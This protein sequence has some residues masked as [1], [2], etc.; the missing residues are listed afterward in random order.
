[1]AYTSPHTVREFLSAAA[2]QVVHD[3]VI[4]C[5]HR[6]AR[7]KKALLKSTREIDLCARLAAFFGAVAHLAAQGIS[8]SSEPDLAVAGPTIRAE[9]KYFR[10][11]ARN[12]ADLTRDR[13]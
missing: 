4:R 12:W 9:V 3:C 10:P 2:L 1:M 5:Q 6:T 13:E 8:A 7:D 11:P